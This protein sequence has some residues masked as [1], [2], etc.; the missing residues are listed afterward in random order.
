MENYVN[1]HKHTHYSNIITPDSA[2]T[3]SDYAKRVVELGQTVLSGLEHG[4]QG[5]YIE[6]YELAKENGL[7]FLFGTEAYIVKDR[8]MVVDDKKDATN[9]H[10][11]LLAKNELGRKGINRILS[12]ANIDGFYYKP[13]IDLELLFTLDK[14]SV[15]VTSACI[16]G[17][18]KYDDYERIF[19]DIYSH[20][21]NNFFLEVQNHDIKR[22]A[23]LN[24]RIINL[25]NRHG[26]NIIAGMDSHY[27]Y[28]QQSKERDDF[29]ASRNIEYE[30][31]VG[32]NM[33]F[34]SYEEAFIRFQKQ[35]ALTDA[36]IKEALNN[37]LVFEQ[38]D[39]YQS[40]IFNKDI[41]LPTLYPKKQQ[42]EKNQIFINLVN[43]KWQIE[44]ENVPRTK[45]NKY[46]KEIKTEVD[47]VVET[48]MA[49][50]FLL[51]YEIIKKGIAD[52]GHITL[53]SRGS[54]PS[55]YISKLLGFTTIDR[56]SAEVKLFP[57]RFITKERI[58]EAGTLPDIDFNLG[59]P[60]IFAQAQKDILGND[61]SY[62]MIA[63]GTAR[64]KA[65]WKIYARAKGIDFDRANDI[66]KDIDRYEMAIKHAEDEEE[67]EQID[68]LDYISPEYRGMF[69][70]SAKYQGIINDIK[71]HP[72]F[73]YNE[74]VLT[75]KGYKKI[76]LINIG[77]KVLGENNQYE[78]VI[79]VIKSTTDDMYNLKIKGYPIISVT[80]NHPFLVRE[81]VR[82]YDKTTKKC[83]VRV[84]SNPKWKAVEDI[85]IDDYVAIAINHNN[86][87]PEIKDIPT[88][89]IHFWWF[90]GRYIGDGWIRKD[91]QHGYNTIVCC[92]KNETAEITS[93]LDELNFYHYYVTKE[94]TI[95][96]I[97]ISNKSL[98]QYLEQF[99]FGAHN[100]HLTNDIIDLPK[101][102]LQSFIEGYISADGYKFNE[103]SYSFRTSSKE[104]ALGMSQCIN[105][106]YGTHCS[107]NRSI[108]RES[109]IGT[110][111]IKG[112][113]GYQCLYKTFK[114]NK[115]SSFNDGEYIW[116]RFESKEYIG[117]LQEAYN[118]EV[119]NSHTYN[120]NNIIVHNCGYLIYD[121]PISEEIGLIRCKDSLCVNMDGSWAEKYSFLKNDLLKVSVVE[122]IYRIYR[123]IGI[124]P[125]SLPELIKLCDGN[126]KVWEVYKNGWTMGINQLEQ[127]ATR[128]RVAKY[129][130]KNISELSAFIAAIRPGFK[131]YY[132]R[133]ESREPFEY[134]IKTLDE[135]IQ[136]EQFPY[137]Y[138]L[139]Q[140]N[141]MQVLAYSGIRISETYE[142][143]KNIAKKRAE[144]VY[145]Y[146]DRFIDGMKN[147]LMKKENL[148]EIASAKVAQNTWQVIED[149]AHYSFNSSHAYSVAGD[150]LY[151]AYLKSHYPL[152]F[153]ETLLTICEED[154]DKDRLAK[155]KEEAKHAYKISF[156]P[157]RFGQDNRNIVLDKDNWAITSS[158]KSI[159]SFGKKVGEDM[160]DLSQLKFDSFFDLLIYAENNG[161]LY[162]HFEKLIYIQYFDNFGG[163]KKLYKFYKEFTE[164]KNRYSS[165]HTD[166][167]KEKRIVALKEYWD[168]L[169]DENFDL[170]VQ[171]SLESD[172]LGNIQAQYDIPKDYLYVMAVDLQYA[173]R[174]TVY[175]LANGK[176]NSIKIRKKVFDENVFYGGEVIKLNLSK[177]SDGRLLY[178]IKEPRRKYVGDGKYE[179]DLEDFDWWA[180]KYDIIPPDNFND[181]VKGTKKK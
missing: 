29:L 36:Q 21:G 162:S 2:A 27:I 137:S 110:R 138:M 159:K 163:N 18:W 130:P 72:C 143:I 58:L 73:D 26:I 5:N 65:S 112:F 69:T 86:I 1:Y 165:K 89:N 51:D 75:D 15:W 42:D 57:E 142:I 94:A 113:D 126:N 38:V 33:D 45:W 129:A 168:S 104:L 157:Y 9:S 127:D 174:A 56:I 92:N 20:F 31:E 149:S 172:I 98:C 53:T 66:S 14:N 28:S 70:E 35:G 154:G 34:P 81:M 55:Y 32:W 67:R 54:A 80:G 48:G 161:I 101:E 44:K 47:T 4:Y 22:Q 145:K 12:Q 111:K 132:S 148:D 85:K 3:P 171:L 152:E 103:S 136:T 114:P 125:H 173:P 119:E 40:R 116:V 87:I 96:R 122:L 95:N 150:S 141:A 82:K 61:N 144:K 115:G 17:L 71:P 121:K 62:P 78:D 39:E 7:K 88:S 84:F 99:G 124:K 140:E 107:V 13:R 52:G 164:G 155:A 41:K 175:C 176:I 93:H 167:T 30:D 11:V 151:G 49:D 79:K 169:Q 16:A 102:L 128:G 83:N 123:R 166:K 23:E 181:I 156:P 146:K 19:L 180:Y 76:G 97:N 90:V 100:K 43:E 64:P 91:K 60:E 106:V 139:Y 170:S 118:L 50:Y 135:L 158:L 134:G 160:Y 153:Y 120:V 68:I 25:S 131:S 6:T 178:F 133:F 24:K 46:E 108:G 59:N 179:D 105:K 117:K 147:R 77:D 10:I 109:Y 8:T 63:Y 177:R 74:L 37:T